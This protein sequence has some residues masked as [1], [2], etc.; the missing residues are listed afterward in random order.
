MFKLQTRSCMLHQQM[1]KIFKEK[2]N[3]FWERI[4]FTKAHFLQT[5]RLSSLLAFKFFIDLSL[6]KGYL[7]NNIRHTS[8]QNDPFLKSVNTKNRIWFQTE[9]RC[10][11]WSVWDLLPSAPCC[12]SS[13][14][15]SRSVEGFSLQSCS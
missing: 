12:S 9:I 14:D 5:R 10:G 13:V 1:V 7:L 15:S 2:I 11:I 3:P 6:L 4:Y 8:N